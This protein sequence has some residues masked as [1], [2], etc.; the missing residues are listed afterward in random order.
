L[1][2]ARLLK[3]APALHIAGK[4]DPLVKFAWQEQTM[5]TLRAVNDCEPD[6][7]TWADNATVFES[8]KGT[9]FV[10]LIHPGGHEFPA[11]A[12]TLIVKFFKQRARD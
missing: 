7:K 11:G 3:P 8:K 10:A 5:N 12:S 4:A 1:R 9:P 6:G 2:T